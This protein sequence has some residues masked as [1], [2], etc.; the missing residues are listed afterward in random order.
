VTFLI[1]LNGPPGIGKSTISALYAD[2]HPGTLNLDIDAL[3]PLV[4][5]WRDPDNHTHEVIRADALAMAA[6]HL[7]G[8]RNVVLPQYL[9]RLDQISRFEQVAVDGGATFLEFIL[10]DDK[11]ESAGRFVRREN[12]TEW[13]QNSRDFVADNGGAR[14]LNRMYDE[15][16]AAAHERPSAVVIR[17]HPG[18]VDET[19][20]QLVS[21]L[22]QTR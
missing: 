18:A 21:L 5:G 19:Y 3:H 7:R 6:A 13:D 14:M 11:E 20:A 1:H 9:G 12:R 15:L 22:D 10:L 16:L 17:S 4:G 8:G 2:R